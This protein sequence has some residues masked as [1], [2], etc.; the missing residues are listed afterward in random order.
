MTT[1]HHV[2][3]HK[4]D[5]SGFPAGPWDDEPDRIEW[6]DEETGLPCLIVRNYYGSLCG[7]VGLP[8]DHPLHG[9]SVYDPNVSV[10][11]GITYAESCAGAICHVP[12]PGEPDNVWWLGFDCGHSGDAL[13]GVPHTI[14]SWMPGLAAGNVYRDVRY[15]RRQTTSLARQLA[16]IASGD[17]EAVEHD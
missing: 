6:R 11:G 5:R 9:C 13:P 17:R 10:H 14:S 15:V 2:A 4:I 1:E 12:Q 16:D 7:Y 3:E 8:P